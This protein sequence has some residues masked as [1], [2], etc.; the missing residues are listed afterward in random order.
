MNL[1]LDLKN[2][3]RDTFKFIDSASAIIGFESTLM[4][5]AF[6]RGKKVYFLGIRGKSRLLRSRNFAWPHMTLEKGLFWNNT[7]KFHTFDKERDI[8]YY[9]VNQIDFIYRLRTF[10]NKLTI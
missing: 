5:E 8:V 6:G 3:N 1:Y 2:K 4:Y 10:E 9:V 7:L